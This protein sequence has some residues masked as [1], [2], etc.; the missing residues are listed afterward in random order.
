MPP[1]NQILPAIIAQNQNELTS[2]LNKITFAENI[3]LDLMDGKFVASSSLDFPM[4]LPEGQQY[5]LHMMAVDPLERIKTLPPQVDTVI[6]HAETLDDIE[7]AISATE[8]QGLK[9]FIAL[10]P[11]TQITAVEPYLEKLNGILIMSVT[12]G[13]YGA[14]FLPEQLAK[15]RAIREK[16]K[17]INIEVDGGMSDKTI[18]LAVAAGANMIA[19]GSFI[20]KSKDPEA[21]YNILRMFFE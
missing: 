12:P 3:M 7:E 14:K 16:S 9:L 17:T 1:K 11:Q 15:V 2:M 20:M 6:M 13:Q 8:K 21:A 19:S 10:N 18:G 4:K 5:Q